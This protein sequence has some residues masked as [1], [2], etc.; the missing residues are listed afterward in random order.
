MGAAP[1]YKLAFQESPSRH[2]ASD[3]RY[4][5]PLPPSATVGYEPLVEAAT[6]GMAGCC[7]GSHQGHSTIRYTFARSPLFVI[8]RAGEIAEPGTTMGRTEIN[9]GVGESAGKLA[10]DQVRAAFFPCMS[11]RGIA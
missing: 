6:P 11:A 8:I 10:A 1:I 4:A 5:T 2:L 7:T 9:M 3:P